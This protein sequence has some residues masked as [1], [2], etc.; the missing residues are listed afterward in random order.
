MATIAIDSTR[1]TNSAMEKYPDAVFMRD[2]AYFYFGND[3]D[4]GLRYNTT[5]TAFEFKG[6][7]IRFSDTQE[8][9]L[10]DGG[11]ATMTW[12][13]SLVVLG[14]TWAISG[15]DVKFSDTQQLQFGDDIDYRM[16]YKAD[17]DV[18]VLSG[19][20]DVAPTGPVGTLWV[21]DAGS[22]VGHVRMVV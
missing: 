7:D 6:G 8:L 21:S 5:Y 18:L 1:Q 12:N 14:G 4:I 13:G 15:A 20:S 11:D 3:G 9:Q 16:Y 10:G 17:S 22:N 2:N 19:L